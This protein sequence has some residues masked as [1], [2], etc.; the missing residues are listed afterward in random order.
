MRSAFFCAQKMKNF[1]V[2]RRDVFNV[3]AFVFIDFILALGR[4]ISPCPTDN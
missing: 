2:L 1:F 3:P 4:V